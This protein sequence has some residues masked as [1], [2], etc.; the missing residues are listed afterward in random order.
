MFMGFKKLLST[1]LKIQVMYFM[2][3]VK[4]MK[5][6]VYL[7]VDLNERVRICQTDLSYLI[8]EEINNFVGGISLGGRRN[9]FKHK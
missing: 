3:F 5:A 6:A 4:W 7:C 2:I 8:S 9:Y 1:H